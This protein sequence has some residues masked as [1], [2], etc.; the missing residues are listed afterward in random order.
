MRESNRV[1]IALLVG[2]V[3]GIVVG[4]FIAGL[5]FARSYLINTQ[6]GIGGAF[7]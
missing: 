1:V 6:L 3:I 2:F 5:V 7:S 4:Y